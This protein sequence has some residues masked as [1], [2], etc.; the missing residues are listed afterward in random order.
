MVL[1][2]EADAPS[3]PGVRE[4]VGGHRQRQRAAQRQ[5]ETDPPA[6]PDVFRL[7]RPH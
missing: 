1:E 3:L 4:H 2:L 5:R 7:S 6:L